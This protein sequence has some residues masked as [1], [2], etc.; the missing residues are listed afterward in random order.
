MVQDYLLKYNMSPYKAHNSKTMVIYR[1]VNCII[2]YSFTEKNGQS[3]PYLG[4]FKKSVGTFKK[5][6]QW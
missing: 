6:A 1:Q 3:S 4:T 2:G 5:S